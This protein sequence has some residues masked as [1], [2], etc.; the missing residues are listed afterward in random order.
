MPRGVGRGG[1]TAI[2]RARAKTDR[3]DARTLVQL[4]AAVALD[5]V[6]M[7]D[8]DTC[9]MRRRPSQRS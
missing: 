1:R 7:P 9:A 5:A 3:L 8:E 6:W 4:L 2:G